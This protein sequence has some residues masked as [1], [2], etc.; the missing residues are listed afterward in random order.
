MIARIEK[1]IS[2]LNLRMKPEKPNRPR[3]KMMSKDVCR[4][5]G[6]DNGPAPP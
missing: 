5:E 1:K 2:F 4:A 3:N 6:V